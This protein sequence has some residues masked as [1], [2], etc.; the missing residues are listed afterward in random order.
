MKSV[1]TKIVLVSLG[2]LAAAG[3]LIFFIILPFLTRI[4]E[5]QYKIHLAETQ[6]AR[7]DGQITSYKETKEELEGIQDQREELSQIFPLREE[8]VGHVEA[9]EG[10]LDE[11]GLF[12]T[13]DLV[14]QKEATVS[15]TGSGK[16]TQAPLVVPKLAAVEEIPY[17]LEIAETDFRGMINFLLYF[18][19]LSFFSEPVKLT[20]TANSLQLGESKIF[21]NTGTANFKLEGILF[22]KNI[23]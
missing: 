4:N 10:A 21:K 22:I 11:A 17:T 16:V 20:V 15:Q 2:F 1:Q 6:A 7:L 9:L 14:D 19:H 5:I 8:L 12:A 3:L 23:R 13:L 18:E